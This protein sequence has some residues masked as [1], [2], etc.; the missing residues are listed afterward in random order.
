MSSLDF[1]KLVHLVFK[2]VQLSVMHL[3]GRENRGGG[4]TQGGGE[5]E[6]EG[7]E[8]LVSVYG[9]SR[10]D[11]EAIVRLIENTYYYERT[12]SIPSHLDFA[13][14]FQTIV[15]FKEHIQGHVTVPVLQLVVREEELVLYAVHCQACLRLCVH[16]PFHRLCSWLSKCT[17]CYASI[18]RF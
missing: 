12:H 11:Y 14:D 9:R 15:S 5:V 13:N 17:R 10:R 2:F 7:I 8:C 6:E 16:E 4:D 3:R 1:V 18:L